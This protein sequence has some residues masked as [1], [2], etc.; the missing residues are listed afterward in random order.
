MGKVTKP[1]AEQAIRYMVG[2]W[3]RVANVNK[4]QSDMP[5]FGDFVSW[6]CRTGHGHYLDFRSTIG[7]MNDV[8][9]WFDDKLGQAWRN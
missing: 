2:Q 1:E 5:S 6:L 8:E 9:R 4:G 3:A 7:P